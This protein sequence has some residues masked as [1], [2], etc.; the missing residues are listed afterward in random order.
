MLPGLAE[1]KAIHLT[2][3]RWLSLANVDLDRRVDGVNG[4]QLLGDVGS[5][6]E[7]QYPMPRV[8]GVRLMLTFNYY[9]RKLAPKPYK[10]ATGKHSN[11]VI[12]VL[13]VKPHYTWTSRE[14]E[15]TYMMNS[16]LDPIHMH[17]EQYAGVPSGGVVAARMSVIRTGVEITFHTKGELLLISRQYYNE[18]HCTI[19]N[20]K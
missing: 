6:Y 8:S 5:P 3:G 11:N 12:C 19:P 15:T 2:L 7:K 16:A 14:P 9:Q 18:V 17:P 13:D 1:G 10:K 20:L 4:G